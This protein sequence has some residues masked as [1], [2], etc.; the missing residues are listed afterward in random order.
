MAIFFLLR[1]SF[2]RTT[3]PLA[4]TE[5]TAYYRPAPEQTAYWRDIKDNGY[6]SVFTNSWLVRQ[7]NR[8]WIKGSR[9][10]SQ[11][12]GMRVKTSDDPQ[13]KKRNYGLY[14]IRR[15]LVNPNS[16]DNKGSW[17]ILKDFYC[18]VTMLRELGVNDFIHC[19]WQCLDHNSITIHKCTVSHSECLV[20]MMEFVLS[21]VHELW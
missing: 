19:H 2:F 1:S 3:R 21:A 10:N 12:S 14:G 4:S 13:L 11:K 17:E 15:E 5:A 8:S 7:R 9:P 6:K 18:S 16:L 20:D